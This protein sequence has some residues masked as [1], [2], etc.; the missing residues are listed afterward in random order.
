ML[1]LMVDSASSLLKLWESRM[2]DGGVEMEVYE[3]L[4]NFSADVISRACFGSDYLKGDE[5]FSKLRALE[6]ALSKPNLLAEIT[7]FRYFS[8]LQIVF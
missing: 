5:I 2:E 8:Q 7:G 6:E 4:R 3:D 1:D